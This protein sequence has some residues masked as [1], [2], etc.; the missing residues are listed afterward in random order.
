MRE[1][2]QTG[3]MTSA[4]VTTLVLGSALLTTWLVSAAVTRRADEPLAAPADPQADHPVSAAAEDLQIQTARLQ[5]RLD[6]APVPRRSSRNPFRFGT[7]TSAASRRPE[8]VEATSLPVPSPAPEPA[9]AP[10]LRL[11]GIAATEEAGGPV[12]TAALSV[13][14]AVVLVRPGDE[15]AGRYRVTAITPDVVELTDRA[16]GPP[17][18]LALR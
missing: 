17:L 12:R 7:R 18:R 14:G 8:T 15:V 4:R 13:A 6:A 5:A 2:D 11:V 9:P 16:G 10:P 3:D 1:H